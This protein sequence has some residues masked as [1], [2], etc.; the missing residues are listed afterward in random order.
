MRQRWEEQIHVSGQETDSPITPLQL[1]M[2]PE[3]DVAVNDDNEPG[4]SLYSMSVSSLLRQLLLSHLHE[5]ASSSP[6]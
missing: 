1:L 3:L 4:T 6:V 2:I 5:N